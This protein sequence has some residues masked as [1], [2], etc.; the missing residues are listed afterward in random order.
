[1]GKYTLVKANFSHQR[2]DFEHIG[3]FG[4]EA[5]GQQNSAV[6]HICFQ[7]VNYCCWWAN[8]LESQEDASASQSQI[9]NC[10]LSSELAW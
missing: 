9:T 10:Y 6:R 7:R 5:Q 4:N 8:K 1:M 3:E 2:F